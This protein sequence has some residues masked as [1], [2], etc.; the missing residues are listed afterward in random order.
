MGRL[1]KLKDRL[2]KAEVVF[3]KVAKEAER[4]GNQVGKE[5]KR[6]GK[7]VEKEAKSAGGKIEAA[8]H[9]FDNKDAR[10]EAS[11]IDKNS[12]TTFANIQ[13]N[14]G[15]LNDSLKELQGQLTG[16]TLPVA[17]DT[18]VAAMLAQLAANQEEDGPFKQLHQLRVQ[19]SAKR[20]Q[21][22]TA[23]S[24]SKAKCNAELSALQ[25]MKSRFDLLAGKLS[26]Q[27]SEMEQQA[28]L[29]NKYLELVIKQH[30]MQESVENMQKA[31]TEV[32]DRWG[33]SW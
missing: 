12:E 2:K 27:Y 9:R 10:D 11:N 33:C 13:A 21:V 23:S 7:Q 18:D 14:Q 26:S 28:A 5:A 1:K 17:G 25:G 31:L 8:V 3:M 19:I 16:G 6:I 20:G 30:E 15:Q 22:S 24:G 4:V 32:A 29:M